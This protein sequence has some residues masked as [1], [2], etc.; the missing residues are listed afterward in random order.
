MPISAESAR[1]YIESADIPDLREGGEGL[2][3][4]V[5]A[6]SFDAAKKQATVV[7]SDVFSFVNGVSAEGR[8]ALVLSSLLAQLVAKKK[9]PDIADID[10]WYKTY[11]DTLTNVGWVIQQ[12]DFALYQEGGLNFEAHRAVLSVA[13]AFLAPAPAAL[14][15]VKATVDALQSMDESRPWLTIF[16]RESRSGKTGRFQISLVEPGSDGEFLVSLLAFS[17]TADRVLTQVLFFKA[18]KEAVQ[19]RHNGAK[20]TIAAS[21]LTGALPAL[22]QKLQNHISKNVAMADI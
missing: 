5:L 14:S 21:V 7:A 17:M 13:A 8:E 6:A 20:V 22:R 18:K 16:D 15:L 19:L 2:D 4:N 11:F 1:R 12:R 3:P 10:G 9:V